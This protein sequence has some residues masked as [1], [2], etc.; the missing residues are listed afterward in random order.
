[1]NLQKPPERVQEL[2]RTHNQQHL[3]AFWDRLNDAERKHLLEQIDAL[4]WPAIDRWVAT[5][6][7]NP[8]PV[9]LPLDRLEPAHFYPARAQTAEQEQKYAEARR[10]GRDLIAAG[11]VAPF[12]VAGGQGTRLGLAGPKGNLPITPIKNKSLFQLFAETIRAASQRYNTTLPW[13]IMTSPLNYEQTRQSFE[14]NDYFGLEP[15]NIFIFQQG[16]LPNFDFDGKLLLADKHTLACSPDGHG[17][18]IKALYESGAIEHLKQHGIE[19]LSYWQV[20]NPLINIF[21]PLFIGLHALEDAEMSAKAA[22]KS[23]PFEKVGNFCCIDGKLTVIEYSDL[24]AELAQ[25]KKADGSLL[26]ELGNIAIH[27]LSVAFVER[28]NR[29]SIAL[30]LHR[31]VKKIPHI[32]PAGKLVQPD[33]PNGVKL[34][35]F[36]FDALPHAHNPVIL[37]AIRTQEFAPTKNLTGPDSIETTRKMIVERAAD[38]LEAAGISVPRKTDGSPD[39]LL[40]IAPSFA[41]YKQDVEEKKDR[42]PPIKPGDSLYLA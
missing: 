19:L 31:A 26:F 8:A 32:D 27:I 20:D 22:I 13:Y 3:L 10:L 39:C 24:P 42:I 33:A 5:V 16:T 23:S 40:E 29:C 4:D 35:T 14:A 9:Q 28:L 34:E 17:G 36:I 41:L 30:P 18:S 1:M 38:W 37:E 25:K 7:K 12:V 2:L 6:V 11:K 21:D 15:D